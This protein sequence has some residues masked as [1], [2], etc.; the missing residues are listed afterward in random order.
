[1]ASQTKF[2]DASQVTVN[3]AGVPIKDAIA[4]PFIELVPRGDSF[5]D[6]IGADGTV[7]RFATNETRWDCTLTLKGH[8]E[9]IVKLSALFGADKSVGNGA[10]VGVFMV[11]DGSGSTLFASDTC[12]IKGGVPKNFGKTLGDVAIT[13]TVVEVDAVGMLAGGN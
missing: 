11:K 10:G 1:M 12:W 8:S 2:Y 5:E 13:L 3:I 4:D 7:V 9:D 6:D